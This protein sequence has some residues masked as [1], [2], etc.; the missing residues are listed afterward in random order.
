[1]LLRLG[2]QTGKAVGLRPGIE[3]STSNGRD[4]SGTEA[5]TDASGIRMSAI[6]SVR[7]QPV[8]PERPQ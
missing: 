5:A 1:M 4:A 6:P 7:L 3:K 8:V 2:A